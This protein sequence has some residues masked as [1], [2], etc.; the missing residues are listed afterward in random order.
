MPKKFDTHDD[1]KEVR[2]AVIHNKPIASSEAFLKKHQML[3]D[4]AYLLLKKGSIKR[5][6]AEFA[7][8]HQ[9]CENTARN[10]L[11]ECEEYYRVVEPFQTRNFEWASIRE[12]I[13]E[14]RELINSFK[15]EK[16][17]AMLLALNTKN[18][19]ALLKEMP[20]ADAIDQEKWMPKQAINVFDPTLIVDAEVS[21]E[22]LQKAILE[23]K[24]TSTSGDVLNYE[25]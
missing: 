5:C 17:R 4:A 3:M 19:I 20:S 23:L 2:L 6:I 14:E 8:T 24:H 21:P 13:L 1:F 7:N 9:V 11:V 22:E 10:Y 15:D 18:R 16:T 25:A 12:Q